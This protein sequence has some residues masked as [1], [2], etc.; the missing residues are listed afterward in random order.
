[1]EKFIEKYIFKEDYDA[2]GTNL[3]PKGSRMA[4]FGLKYSFKKGDV[5]NGEMIHLDRETMNPSDDDLYRIEINTS[6]ALQ[7][8][9]KIWEGQAI[10]QVPFSVVENQSM[11]LHKQK[12][13][14]T[15]QLLVMLGA[16]VIGYFAYKKFNK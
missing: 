3:I 1:M 7:S 16:L 12:Q 4:S 5:F 2:Q 13:K 9:G 15:K 10:F 11:F 6:S 14:Q 8:D